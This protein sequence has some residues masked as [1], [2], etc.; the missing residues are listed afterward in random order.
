MGIRSTLGSL[1]TAPAA[2]LLDGAIRELVA[3]TLAARALV[4]QGEV[5]GLADRLDQLRRDMARSRAD[6]DGV[7]QAVDASQAGLL[8]PLD[9][10]LSDDLA[11]AQQRQQ[12][13]KRALSRL[14]G[15]IA[16][17]ADQVSGLSKDADALR[18]RAEQAHQL[19]TTARAT[20]EAAADAAADA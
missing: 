17:L 19:A 9:A 2:A 8:D 10:D 13:L 5:D 7:Q 18:N 12:E 20:A 14:D 15:A 11:A 1:V 16:A 6:L 4:R 3:E